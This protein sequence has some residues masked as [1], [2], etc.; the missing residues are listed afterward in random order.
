[1]KFI[2]ISIRTILYTVLA[3]AL[4]LLAAELALRY[5]L[6]TE[7]MQK[8]VV[9]FIS[10]KSK[11][12]V[13]IKN[14]AAGLT[15]I[16]LDNISIKAPGGEEILQAKSVLVKILPFQLLKGDI[17]FNDI[18]IEGLK[19]NVIRDKNGDF[20]FEPFFPA[21]GEKENSNDGNEAKGDSFLKDLKIKHIQLRESEI[22]YCDL[23]KNIK[24]SL[25]ELFLDIDNFSFYSP[26]K[27]SVNTLLDYQQKSFK[28]D[29]LPLGFTVTSALAGMNWDNA[30]AQIDQL[31]LERGDS[32]LKISGSVTDFLNPD[33]QLNTQA[34][35]FSSE[36]LNGLFNIPAFYL[37][38]AEVDINGSYNSD[39]NKILI[40]SFNISAL[41]SAINGK[42]GIILGDNPSYSLDLK[43]ALA[44]GGF[45]KAISLLGEYLLDGFLSASLKLGQGEV[46]GRVSAKNVGF[47][48]DGAGTFSEVNAVAEIKTLKNITLN[49]L[50]GRLNGNAFKTALTYLD[51]GQS[52]DVNFNLQTDRLLLEKPKKVS[53]DSSAPAE[54]NPEAEP[55]LDDSS[56]NS[57]QSGKGWFL[58]PLNIKGTAKVAA[59]ESPYFNAYDV[60]FRADVRNFTPSLAGISGHLALDTDSGVIKDLYRLT[61]ANALTK[62]LFVSL[63]VVS[64]LINSLDVLSLLNTLAA[65]IL[66]T[67]K[68]EQALDA[69]PDK[70]SGALNYESFAMDL[71]FNDGISD[72]KRGDFVSSLISL[73]MAGQINFNSR[74]ID[75]TVNAAPGRI[76]EN[77]IMPLKIKIG[78][79]IDDPSGKMSMLSSATSLV[80]QT[81]FKNPGSRIVKKSLNG[82][83]GIFGLSSKGDKGKPAAEANGGDEFIPI[84]IPSSENA[85]AQ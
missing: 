71:D 40:N 59:L 37:G 9:A 36:A 3:A 75:M 13:S 15:G 67:D 51:N 17:D 72:I 55:V 53:A 57:A 47:F 68:Q 14:I 33:I 20:N 81:I 63:G 18:S 2:R 24:I 64:K 76:S 38:K 48:Y 52:A 78:G 62:V 34:N 85:P 79:T 66:P 28:L 11:G 69:S 22:S 49:N 74:G 30:F 84:E 10:Q 23:A 19:L 56:A 26:F 16:H 82:I 46:R 25:K 83:L 73:N 58:P 7:G 42:G 35:N 45:S 4:L 61:N 44:L 70:I 31:V 50:N 41:N 27:L 29:N 43:I 1:M 8:K 32:L 21:G 39:L 6:P 54:Y 65:A 60:N 12:E 5:L 80:R 77:G